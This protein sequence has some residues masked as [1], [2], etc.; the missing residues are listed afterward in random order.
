MPAP[1]AVFRNPVRRTRP[2]TF[3]TR[4]A[5][6]ARSLVRWMRRTMVPRF[7]VTDVPS[8]LSYLISITWSPRPAPCCCR[9]AYRRQVALIFS[10]SRDR[11]LTWTVPMAKGLRRRPLGQ[12]ASWKRRRRCQS[13]PPLAGE[14]QRAKS[15]QHAQ[16]EVLCVQPGH[17]KDLRD[18][19]S[20]PSPAMGERGST[21]CRPISASWSSPFG[22]LKMMICAS[23]QRAFA[24]RCGWTQLHPVVE[25]H[26]SH[27]KHVPLR[28]SV[29]LP[30][31]PH[32][33]PT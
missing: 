13:P 1:H 19:S 25:P 29:K 27:F 15:N 14:G 5:A 9:S 28:T 17:Y 7:S 12:A 3:S 4:H 33:S 23:T 32:E 6:P 31:S 10:S 18:L 20:A 16:A 30:H 21:H 24:L 26:V 11:R 2:F 8:T 22:R